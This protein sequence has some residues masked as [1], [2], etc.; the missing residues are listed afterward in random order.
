MS[1]G[2]LLPWYQ[3]RGVP[4][5]GMA[6]TE[7]GQR[8]V[9]RL[10]LSLTATSPLSRAAPFEK[11]AQGGWRRRSPL[12][13]STNHG[14]GKQITP[15]QQ[16]FDVTDFES[17]SKSSARRGTRDILTHAIDRGE[18]RGSAPRDHRTMGHGPS[19][20]QVVQAND[21]TSIFQECWSSRAPARY[22]KRDKDGPQR[23]TPTERTNSWLESP[24]VPHLHSDGQRQAAV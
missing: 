18:C 6:S 15:A 22:S 5:R 10:R 23:Q 11:E 24:A 2:P 17:S 16:R 19:A 13:A 4:G 21:A 20:P 12:T 14:A 3:R 1:V 9:E 8:G 7:R